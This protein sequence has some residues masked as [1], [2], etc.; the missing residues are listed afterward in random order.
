MQQVVV[1]DTEGALAADRGSS[2]T[3]TVGTGSTS[4]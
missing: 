4:Y 2:E 3:V 1:G